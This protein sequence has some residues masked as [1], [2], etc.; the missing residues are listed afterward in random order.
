MISIIT[1]KE[2]SEAHARNQDH[3]CSTSI[4]KKKKSCGVHFPT[5]SFRIPGI[6]GFFPQVLAQL[7]ANSPSTEAG[8]PFTESS[9][10]NPWSRPNSHTKYRTA[11]DYFRFHRAEMA[12]LLRA[13][14]DA[15]GYRR[16]LSLRFL[17]RNSAL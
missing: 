15:D 5:S 7:I 12:T 17:S 4:I 14:A 6:L 1:G 8:D 10:L 2:K 11:V 13:C 16:C 3:I 9:A